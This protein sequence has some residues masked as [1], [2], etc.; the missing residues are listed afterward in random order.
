MIN[1]EVGAEMLW[2]KFESGEVTGRTVP[3]NLNFCRFLEGIH[4]F[5][6]SK[7]GCIDVIL[8]IEFILAD[9][10][11]LWPF[12]DPSLNL[13]C[14]CNIGMN[15][16]C[17]KEVMIRNI[18]FISLI[19]T[20]D[21]KRFES[22]VY[23][24]QHFSSSVLFIEKEN[25][26]EMLSRGSD[27]VFVLK[28]SEDSESQLF[29]DVESGTGSESEEE[30]EMIVSEMEEIREFLKL[31][32]GANSEDCSSF[33]RMKS[34]EVIEIELSVGI[35]RSEDFNSWKSLK[36]VIFSSG[37]NLRKIFGFER[38]TSLC[39]IE[40]PSSVEVIGYD[41]FQG[42]TS[43]NQIVFSSDSHLKSIDGFRKC[44]SLCR[45]EIPSSVEAIGYNGFRG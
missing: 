23:K 15:W 19:S 25:V 17:W 7:F 16:F 9:V 18:E 39:R 24:K 20:S 3:L 44:T 42:C 13:I 12:F 6:N 11:P 22:S 35:I 34:T 33:S 28:V 38:C 26:V 29:L 40:I 32:G 5:R 27:Y 36:R 10:S 31:S 2:M 8:S 1:E 43:L 14:Y 37:N 45:I 41:G 4:F 30:R 21:Q